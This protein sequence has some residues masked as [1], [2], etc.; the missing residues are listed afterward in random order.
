MSSDN[1]VD[2]LFRERRRSRNI[3]SLSPEERQ[4]RTERLASVELDPRAFERSWEGWTRM[5]L[6]KQDAIVADRIA[7]FS[8]RAIAKRQ[9]CPYALVRR[10]IMERIL[11]KDKS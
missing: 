6:E 8:Y 3:R 10:V 5:R 1:Y 2:T 11:H 9:N 4:R 7:G